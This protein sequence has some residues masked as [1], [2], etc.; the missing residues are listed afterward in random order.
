MYF[1]FEPLIFVL[2][3]LILGTIFVYA[4]SIRMGIAVGIDYYFNSKSSKDKYISI[5]EKNNK[6]N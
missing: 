5:R 6:K 4:S 1:G 2:V 3:A